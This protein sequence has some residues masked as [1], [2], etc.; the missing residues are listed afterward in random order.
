VQ[1]SDKIITESLADTNIIKGQ[2]EQQ[3]RIKII[4][5]CIKGLSAAGQKERAAKLKQILSQI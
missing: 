5:D 1:D 4:E 2:Q 3:E